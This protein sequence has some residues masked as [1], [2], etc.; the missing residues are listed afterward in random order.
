MHRLCFLAVLLLIGCPDDDDDSFTSIEEPDD[1]DDDFV[2]DDDDDTPDLGPDGFLRGY[3]VD[4][5]SAPRVEL[6]VTEL[7]TEPPNAA[8]TDGDGVFLLQ[9]ESWEPAQLWAGGEGFM[10]IGIVVTEETYLGVGQPLLFETP[11]REAA[12]EFIDEVFDYE[13]VPETGFVVALIDTPNPEDQVGMTATLDAPSIGPYY[14]D[15]EGSAILGGS[16]P[17]ADS[18]AI[19]WVGVGHGPASIEVTPNPG[20]TCTVP[21]VFQALGDAFVYV[22][23]FC[24]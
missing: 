20:M 12:I 11:E 6:P 16:I 10:E 7:D 3:V 18:G 24:Q 8:S 21:A 4:T 9:P 5:D 23:V 13:W 22:H 19:A 2:P 15:D 1:D 17:V 14:F